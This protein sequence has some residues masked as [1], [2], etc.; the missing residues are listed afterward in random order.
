[1]SL[2]DKLGWF[3]LGCFIG[4]F[5]GY[6]TRE[7]RTIK[8]EL[9]EVDD[10]VKQNHDR[11]NDERGSAR[12]P[13]WQ[14]VA[15]AIVV[16]LTAYAAF[17]SQKAIDNVEDTQTQVVD[18]QKRLNQIA[19]CN[20]AIIK[21]AVIAL[22]ERT[23][24]SAESNMANINLQ[25]SQEAFFAILLH[26]PPYN[27]AQ[28]AHAAQRYFHDLKVFLKISVSQTQKVAENDYPEKDALLTCIENIAQD[29]KE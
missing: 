16:L 21:Q 23:S 20:Q 7:L 28:R 12:L 18:T 24:L 11:Q 26:K 29:N 19:L 15:L 3:V 6:I 9:D 25:R 17:A 5:I 27:E 13:S 1:M 8:E 14:N 22:N 2:D 4:F 10:I